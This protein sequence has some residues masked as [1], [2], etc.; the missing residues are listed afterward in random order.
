MP[1]RK[2]SE[3]MEIMADFFNGISAEFNNLEQSDLPTTCDRSIR[4]ISPSMI[5]NRVRKMKWP[6]SMVPGD[7]PPKIMLR[8]I[9]S[10]SDPLAD[11]FNATS[12]SDWPRLWKENGVPD[13]Y[14]QEELTN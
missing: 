10:L 7:I 9:E 14:T 5:V 12:H 11:I 3:S 13:S 6:R 2:L 1:E 4:Y 8:V